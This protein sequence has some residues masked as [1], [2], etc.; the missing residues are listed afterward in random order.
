MNKKDRD[1]MERYIYQV[2]RRLPGDQRKEV[3]LELEELI[4][5]MWE[6]AEAAKETDTSGGTSSMDEILTKLGNPADFAK[7]YQD[8]THY[9]IGP[10]YFDTYRWFMK[11]V[12]VGVLISVLVVGVLEGFREVGFSLNTPDLRI[13]ARVIAEA[14]ADMIGNGIVSAMGAFGAVT[15]IFALLERR[16]VKLDIGKMAKWTAREPGDNFSGKKAGWTTEYLEPIPHKKALIK[17]SDSIVNIILSVFVCI[18]FLLAPELF[19][20]VSRES[21]QW[22]TVPVLNLAEWNR[23]YPWILLSMLFGVIDSVVRLAVGHYCKTVMISGIVFGG[24]LQIVTCIAALKTT[25]F[26]NTDF[27]EN[28]RQLLG[29][30]FVESQGLLAHWNAGT[31]TN[32]VLTICLIVILAEVAVTVYKT[33]RYGLE[34]WEVP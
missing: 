29:E 13:L 9:V 24:I 28:C 8:D 16:R 3:G 12:L 17:R 4:G 2:V 15:L 21:G 31:I 33:L 14:V 20:L 1:L 27:I 10:E 32:V 6:A 22:V 7:K 5:D 23:I 19:A 11:V 25:T 30:V 34:R 26:W 18:L